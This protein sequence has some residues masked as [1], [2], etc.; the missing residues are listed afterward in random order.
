MS[1]ASDEK[2]S[3]LFG[4]TPATLAAAR[5]ALSRGGE[6]ATDS[7]GTDREYPLAPLMPSGIRMAAFRQELDVAVRSVARAGASDETVDALL[8]VSLTIAARFPDAFE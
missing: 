8:A 3:T 4:V 1:G 2:A 5:N 6:V 7:S